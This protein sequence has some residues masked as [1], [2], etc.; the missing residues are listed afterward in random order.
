[1][2]Y[3]LVCKVCERLLWIGKEKPKASDSVPPV[4][5]IHAEHKTKIGLAER[6]QW[7]GCKGRLGYTDVAESGWL[8]GLPNAH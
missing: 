7:C 3:G 2:N 6:V 5:W 4:G 1:M 8:K